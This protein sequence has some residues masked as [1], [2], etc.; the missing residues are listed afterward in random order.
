MSN[1]EPWIVHDPVWVDHDFCCLL[2]GESTV[3]PG[4]DTLPNV[5][6]TRGRVH[7]LCFMVEDHIRRRPVVAAANAAGIILDSSSDES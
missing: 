6:D 2:C 7:Y 1:E 4:I 3:G 5:R